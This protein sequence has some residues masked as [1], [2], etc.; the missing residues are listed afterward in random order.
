[1]VAHECKKDEIIS[2]IKKDIENLYAVKDVVIELKTLTTMQVEQNKKQDEILRQQSE[3]MIKI[4]DTL[5]Q[6]GDLIKKCIEQQKSTE[7]AINKQI[8]DSS[9]SF[10]EI[11]KEGLLKYVPPL[12]IAGIMYYI[13]D[14]TK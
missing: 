2:D 14:L 8:K 12:L 1:M 3:T 9:I 4:T 10:N 5:T 13:L 6:Q 11:I 7:D